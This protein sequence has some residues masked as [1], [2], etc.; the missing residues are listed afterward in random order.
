M[1]PAHAAE[2]QAWRRLPQG[3]P[4][5]SALQH[6]RDRPAHVLWPL[7]QGHGGGHH[8]RPGEEEVQR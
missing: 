1:Q 2:A 4:G 8:V 7:R 5:R 6:H 3:V